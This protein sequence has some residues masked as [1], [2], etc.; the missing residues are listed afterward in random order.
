MFEFEFRLIY[1]LTLWYPSLTLY[2]RQKDFIWVTIFLNIRIYVAKV[3]YL[4]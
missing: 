1:I 3:Q 2:N 4:K